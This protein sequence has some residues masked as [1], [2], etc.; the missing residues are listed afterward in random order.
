M[1]ATQLLRNMLFQPHCAGSDPQCKT[2]ASEQRDARHRERLVA[3][4]LM[5]PVDFSSLS[6]VLPIDF[7]RFGTTNLWPANAVMMRMP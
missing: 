6:M 2:D 7:A 3:F 5:S 1:G 4:L